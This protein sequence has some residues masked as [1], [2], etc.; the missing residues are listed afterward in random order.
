MR[1]RVYSGVRRCSC[2]IGG[3]D[4][5]AI[6][7]PIKAVAGFFWGSIRTRKINLRV[8]V[9]LS[10]ERSLP[11]S[12]YLNFETV[13][14]LSGFHSPLKVTWRSRPSAV[15]SLYA[16]SAQYFGAAQSSILFLRSGLSRA[17]RLRTPCR[18]HIEPKFLAAA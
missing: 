11:G 7:P 8:S 15:M 5:G 18:T 2:M 6:C 14:W 12:C 13:S 1:E 4:T 16:T 3:V 17:A 9:V 10:S